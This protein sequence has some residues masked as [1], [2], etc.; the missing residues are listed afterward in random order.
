MNEQELTQAF[1]AIAEAGDVDE[2][3]AWD[4][5]QARLAADR[6]A[7]TRRRTL[8]TIA[9]IALAGSAAAGFVALAG[10][11]APEA[12]NTVPPATS[13]EV[14]TTTPVTATTPE[15]VPSS[16][17]A[18]AT[19]VVASADAHRVLSVDETGATTTLFEVPDDG[20][21]IADL[22]LAPDGAVFVQLVSPESPDG[23][24]LEVDADG[25]STPVMAPGVETWAPAVSAD[26]RRL[27][28]LARGEGTVLAVVD[29]V[30]G[31]QRTMWWADDDED[32]F[33]TQGRI[34][35][36][37][38]S[39]DGT[40]LLFTSNYEG[41]EV[42]VLDLDTATTL[43][44]AIVVGG[45][46]RSA[47]WLADGRIVGIDDCCYPDQDRNAGIIDVLASTDE[48]VVLSTTQA[49]Q[50]SAGA[51]GLFGLAPEG[52]F[53]ICA[54]DCEGDGGGVPLEAGEVFDVL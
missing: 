17:L 28:F 43:S 51:G 50:L 30:T 21:T 24:V 9:G 31:E 1:A 39:P 18:G 2:H 34:S 10:D 47:T 23:V 52:V 22:E 8:Y 44:D 36:L 26:G 45:G 4:A 37:A 42:L 13:P 19:I 16:P 6:K 3:A 32:F 33:H 41:S 11:D 20:S 12:I 14:P 35:D 49:L 46:V 15:T 29:R 53:R 27:A 5:I 25:A 48:P 7:G 54:G 38:F 40:Q